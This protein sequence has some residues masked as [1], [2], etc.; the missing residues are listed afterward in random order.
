MAGSLGL[1]PESL[2]ASGRSSDKLSLP[3][4]QSQIKRDPDGY[5]TEIHLIYKQFRASVDLFQQQAALTFSSV[6]SDPSVAKDLGDRAMFLAHVTPFYPKQLAAFPAQLTDLLRTSCLAMPSVLRIHVVKALILLM[7]RKS[8]VMEDLLALFLDIQTLGDENMRK[9]A[10]SH[11]VQTIRKMSI[12]D[13]RHK[14]LQKIV[15][16]MLEQEDETKAKRALVTLCELHKR[17]VWFGD[18]H[19]RVAI[20]I[21]EACFHT[22]PRI[23][24]SSLRFLLDYDNIN[25]ED[26]SDASSSDD[27][28][29]KKVSQVV[30]NREAVYKAN[31]KGTSS[32]KKKKQAKLQRAM[33]SIKRKQRASSENTTST[34]SPLNHLNDAQNFAKRLLRRIRPKSDKSSG[35][36]N[37]KS[38]GETNDKSSG[39]TNDKSSGETNEPR[40]TRLMIIK[41]I[42]RTISLHKLLLF[43]FY[44]YLQ[45]Y[46]K[47]GVKDIT[48]ILAAAV[49]AC[50]DGVPSDAVEPLFKKIVNVFLHDRSSPEAIPVALNVVREMCLRIPELMTEDLLHDLAQYKTDKKYR[51]HRKAI[52][53]ASASLIALFR[54]INPSL[55]VKKDRGRPGGPIARP[56]K[57]GEVNVF[58]NV[59]NVELLQE[60]D[61]E[62]DD[63][64]VALPGSDG[65]EQVP[66]ACG[67]EDEAEEVSNYGDDMNI[68]ED[69]SDIDDVALPGSDDIEQELIPDACGTEDEAEED[70][71]DGDDMNNTEDDTL[72]SGDEE[73]EKNDSDEAETDS[74]NE[75]ED[76]G[77]ASDSSV[78]GSGN[79]E[80]AKGKKR[81]LVD[82]DA[83]LL[84]ADTSLR[85]LKRCAEAKREQPSFAESDGILSNEDFQKIK[86]LKANKDAKI[87][88]ARKG[89]K[90][91]DSDQL[92]KK[93]VN[94]AKLE[95][96]ITH[97]LTKEERLE[98]VKA[99]REDRGKYQSKTAIKQK[100]SGGSS[101]RQKEHK[102]NMPLA[103]IRSKAGKSKRVKKKK[104]SLSGSQFRGRKAWK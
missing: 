71:N 91:P 94:P 18:K 65:S 78:E 100:K 33:R 49:Q 48:Q 102:K 86:E 39:E 25:D 8:L 68:T 19:D 103:A 75:E 97:K 63:D 54:E 29:S 95:A 24:I 16:S 90:V 76:D 22:S 85:A 104:N 36:T 80:K 72:V 31:N 62:K 41:V 14:S 74:E 101:N 64:E 88:L 67:T 42:A 89:F 77:E 6:G 46:A 60:S 50:H 92:S 99:G 20:A 15:V 57:Y 93:L 40:E 27:E 53:A 10:F 4:L 35:E 30:F 28:D 7:N 12:T 37:D 9:L 83:S 45:G 32:S 70:S 44:T 21:C 82:F 87:A 56:K 61:N 52:S 73:E 13:P 79:T 96:H 17:K 51:T 11:I 26:D 69:D 66:D 58:S 47:D 23:R 43:K 2:K 98:L 81:K 59:P 55:L 38:S 34:Y 3:I 5:E 1:T 84:A